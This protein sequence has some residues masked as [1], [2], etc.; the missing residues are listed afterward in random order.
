MPHLR[1]MR[2]RPWPRG[3]GLLLAPQGAVTT[4]SEGNRYGAGSL[5]CPRVRGKLRRQL[6]LHAAPPLPLLSSDAA[7]EAAAAAAS[8]AARGA[9]TRSPS[10]TSSSLGASS[11]APEEPRAGWLERGKKARGGSL[12]AERK[13]R[14]EESGC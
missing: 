14:G 11:R 5:H 6:R 8:P 7:V 4:C 13:G 2:A 1:V 10:P 9:P 3:L 12:R